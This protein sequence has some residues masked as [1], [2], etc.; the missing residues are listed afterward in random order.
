MRSS[1]LTL[2]KVSISVRNT[3][4]FIINF[5][6]IVALNIIFKYGEL[7]ELEFEFMIYSKSLHFN[8]H[9]SH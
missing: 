8:N 5:L 7:T 4:V 2:L 9:N 1:D 6:Q 3:K